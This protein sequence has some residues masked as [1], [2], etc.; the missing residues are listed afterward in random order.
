MPLDFQGLEDRLIDIVRDLVRI[1]TTNPPGNEVEAARYLA[2]LLSPVGIETEIIEPHPGRG[3]LVARLRGTGE[4]KPLVLMGHLDVVAANPS[5]WS[6]PPFAAEI[7][8]GFIWG[9]GSTDMKDMIGISAVIMLAL[10]RLGQ[11]LKRDVVMMATADEEQGGDWGMGWLVQH[12]PELFDVACAINEGGGSSLQVG[13]NLFYTCQ[14]AEKGVCR[15]VWTARGKGG[16]G[17]HPRRDIATLQLTRALN[18][19]GDG[20]LEARVIDTMRVALTMIA[21]ARSADAMER[22]VALLDQGKIPEAMAAA[23][24]DQDGIERYRP[25]F[26]DTVSVTGLRAGDPRYINVIPPVA[27]AYLDGRILPGQTSRGFLQQLRDRVSNDKVE[28]EIYERQYAQGSESSTDAPIFQTI[29]QVVAEQCNAQ[30]IPWQCQGATDA[31][32][33]L[34]LGIPVYGFVPSRPLPEGVE[35]AG[36]HANNERV[37]IEN[38]P[39]ALHILGE[40]AYRFC[41]D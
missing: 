30:V 29:S 11:P 3:N 6:Y 35:G 23:G 1:D 18:Q 24:F 9:R 8:D 31:K 17:S 10:A 4:K 16:H 39:F 32:H 25:M 40:I 13:D 19:I 21:S 28:I 27:T 7:H 26:H 15:T 41:T 34:S 12:R 33:L 2:D 36:P 14:S 5:D 38:L 37:W 20:Y 22:T